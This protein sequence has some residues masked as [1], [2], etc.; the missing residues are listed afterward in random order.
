MLPHLSVMTSALLIFEPRM[1]TTTLDT[2]RLMLLVQRRRALS[3]LVG[4]FSADLRARARHSVTEPG[5][6][7][8]HSWI[9]GRF[10]GRDPRRHGNGG[11]AGGQVYPLAHRILR[12]WPTAGRGAGYGVTKFF[13]HGK[14]GRVSV[15][16][17]SARSRDLQRVEQIT[18]ETDARCFITVEDIR[19]LQMG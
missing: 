11:T 6:S 7:M 16:T 15:V 2:L 18:A 14:E 3:A 5:Q 1:V 10:R 8:E 19:Q 9:R 4:F 12:L 17:C 13:G